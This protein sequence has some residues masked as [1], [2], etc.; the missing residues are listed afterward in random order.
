MR[1]AFTKEEWLRDYPNLEI[2]TDV[3]N[4]KKFPS[5]GFHY[6]CQ[7]RE[8]IRKQRI[9]NMPNFCYVYP[10]KMT[11]SA[12]PL[13]EV[14]DVETMRKIA[15]ACGM[16]KEEATRT[17]KTRLFQFIRDNQVRKAMES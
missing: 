14:K 15:M 17:P 5:K 8:E 13:L 6:N 4:T 2:D 9:K 7:F 11:E 16:S 3:G 1:D 12:N 10:E